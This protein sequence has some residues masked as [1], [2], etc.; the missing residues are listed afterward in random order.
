M[1]GRVRFTFDLIGRLRRALLPWHDQP[2]QPRRPTALPSLML[3]KQHPSQH[4]GIDWA[5]VLQTVD[6]ST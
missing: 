2:N 1:L 4:A 5:F 3:T 6:P